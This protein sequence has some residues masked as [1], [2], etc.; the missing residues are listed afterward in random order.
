MPSHTPSPLLIYP[1]IAQAEHAQTRARTCPEQSARSSFAARPQR[2]SLDCTVMS[3][4]LEKCT[5]RRLC[6]RRSQ[7]HEG[8]FTGGGCTLFGEVHEKKTVSQKEPE[9]GRCVSRCVQHPPPSPVFPPT[10][11]LFARAITHA[12]APILVAPVDC[13]VKSYNE[14]FI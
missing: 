14:D 9:T 2:S 4:Y 11:S 7:K 13:D 10:M 12:R 8:A 5:K 6:R 1:N 3:C